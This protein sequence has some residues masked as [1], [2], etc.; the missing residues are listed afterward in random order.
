IVN[1]RDEI[2]VGGSGCG[3]NIHNQT[4]KKLCMMYNGVVMVMPY[5]LGMK[6]KVRLQGWLG[7]KANHF[8]LPV[9]RSF[10]GI[11]FKG[12]GFGVVSFKGVG[13]GVMLAGLEKVR[14]LVELAESFWLKP[15]KATSLVE[16]A[17]SFWLQLEKA[18]RAGR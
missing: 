12:V 5:C 2:V 8:L 17:V 4:E 7:G 10:G 14:N 15:D 3:L 18:R 9:V 6:S 11:G 13:F 1:M 16:L